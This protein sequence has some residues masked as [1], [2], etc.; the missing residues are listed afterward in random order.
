MPSTWVTVLASQPSV[1]I[2][3][4]TTHLI[5][6]PRRPGLPTVF[7]TSRSRSSSVMRL[8]VALGEALAVLG[9]ELVDLAGRELLELGRQ[10]LAGLELRGVDEDG[11]GA[12]A[13]T[14]RA[15]RC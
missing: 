4:V 12:V 15:P 9:L 7:M 5:C 3:T 8:G 10:R 11:V 13:S 6:S 1:S 14:D 2:E